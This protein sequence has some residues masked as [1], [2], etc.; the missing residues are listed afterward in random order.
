MANG[1]KSL[2][3]TLFDQGYEVLPILTIDAL[4]HKT[5]EPHKAAGKAPAVK[6]WQSIVIDEA[7]VAKWS[8]QR[9]NCGVGIRTRKNPA[10]DIDCPNDDAAKH[11][12][13]FVE[14]EVG[15]APVR[16]GRAP[17]LLLLYTTDRPFTK[18]KSKVWTDDDGNENAV[19]ILGSGQQFVAFGIHPKTRKPYSWVT[20]DTPLTDHA[21]FDLETISLED[22]RKIIDEFDRYAAEQGW[23]HNPKFHQIRGGFD[24]G[25]ELLEETS[26]DID[27]D[28]DD[29]VT[30]DILKDKW[31]G[32]YEELEAIFLNDVEPPTCYDDWY[33]VLAALKDA[34]REPDDYMEIAREWSKR[35]PKHDDASFEDKW[36]H[37]GFSR[38][39]RNVST[40]YGIIARSKQLTELA[41]LEDEVIPLFR[42]AETLVEWELAA[43]RL[44][45][46]AVFGAAREMAVSV[47]TEAFKRVTGSKLSASSAKKQLSYDFTQFPAPEWLK[48]WVYVSDDNIFINQESMERMKP[49]AFANTFNRETKKSMGFEA[50]EF[51]TVECPVP[52]V[53]NT[54]YYPAAHGDMPGNN[55]KRATNGADGRNFFELDGRNYLNEFDPSTIPAEAEKYTKKGKLAIETVKRFFDIQYPDPDERRHALDWM[56]W[57]INNPCKKIIYA[58]IVLGGQGSGKTIVKKFMEKMLGTVNV[59][60]ISNKV[61]HGAFTGWQAGHILKVIEEISVSGHRY[62]V[63]NSLKEPITNERLQVEDK[64]LTAKQVINTASYMAFTNDIGALPISKGDRRFLLIRS[65]FQHKEEVEAFLQ[66]NPNYFKSF[67]MAFTKYPDQIRKWFSEWKYSD[68]F[69]YD[70]HAPVTF[71][72][73]EMAV[74]SEDDFK[75]IVAGSIQASA[76]DFSHD[77]GLTSELIH[78]YWAK[79]LVN[80]QS[81]APSGKHMITM[82]SEIGFRRLSTSRIQ[83]RVNGE[84]GTVFARNPSR[85]LLPDG[86]PDYKRIKEHF[87]DH[88]VKVA[89]CN[90]EME[91]EKT[92]DAF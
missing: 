23:K 41:E 43:E 19:E 31:D 72:M 4:D 70:G 59:Q 64:Y 36:N 89:A 58:M 39:G 37:G 20:K 13:L 55:W 18:V 71:G 76:Q 79:Y 51:A 56:A 65:G 29:W 6:S 52:V 22:A 84:R 61:I 24:D 69:K 16:I 17:K 21:D 38:A 90:A 42:S 63:M 60:T 34:G 85:W 77:T 81:R 26:E 3:K 83:I 12:R 7:Q 53:S 67:E 74:D 57:V 15:F 25:S 1:F 47:A 9:R 91:F 87:D 49:P 54:M 78:S 11:M 2:G 44:R 50:D 68:D 48:P 75:S 80:D 27:P 10:V 35:G 62:D 82:L 28:E 5:G 30:D 8:H 45:L 86:T 92:A 73:E 40:I 32:T 66:D 46:V 88:Q 33:P 14:M